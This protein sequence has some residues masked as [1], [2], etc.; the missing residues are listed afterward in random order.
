MASQSGT[1]LQSNG[2]AVPP[3]GAQQDIYGQVQERHDG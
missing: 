3:F 1:L 2:A